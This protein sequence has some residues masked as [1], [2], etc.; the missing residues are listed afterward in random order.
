[1]GE[2]SEHCAL[3]ILFYPGAAV[4][5]FLKVTAPVIN[6]ADRRYDVRIRHFSKW[7]MNR[8]IC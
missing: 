6:L 3:Q 4:A 2:A 8:S 5:R 1:M 7:K